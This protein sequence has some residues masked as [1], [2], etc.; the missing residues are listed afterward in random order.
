MRATRI[1]VYVRAWCCLKSNH[2]ARGLFP[3]SFIFRNITVRRTHNS[4]VVTGIWRTHCRVHA[5]GARSLPIV[6]ECTAQ[7][8]AVVPLSQC[9]ADINQARITCCLP[10]CARWHVYLRGGAV[11]FIS[12][13]HLA[14]IAT[15][16]SCSFHLPG[17]QL[18]VPRLSRRPLL[19]LITSEMS[20]YASINVR[21][22]TAPGEEF[23][24]NLPV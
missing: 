12:S 23:N 10:H 24:R 15:S 19:W 13:T 2:K 4:W 16:L 18:P 11:C 9:G 17:W 1:P 3:A 21:P 5:R 20:Y 22:L 8:K 6:A 7:S 14:E